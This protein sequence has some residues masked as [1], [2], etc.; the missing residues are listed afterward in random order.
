[1]SGSTR[2][3]SNYSQSLRPQDYEDLAVTQASFESLALTPS[4]GSQ[5]YQVPL[6]QYQVSDPIYLQQDFG[7]T[8]PSTVYFHPPYGS[9]NYPLGSP[10]SFV[11]S[12]QA[13]SS[14]GVPTE[15]AL[16]PPTNL[17]V[18][19]SASS[20]PQAMPGPDMR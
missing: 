11:E 19:D 1:M 12:P 13:Y 15:P 7:R 5:R 16:P 6:S 4:V 9:A 3:P 17:Y 20:E 10:T 18:A 8:D 14:I 2:H